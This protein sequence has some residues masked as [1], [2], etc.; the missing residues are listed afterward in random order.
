MARRTLRL[1]KREPVRDVKI[2]IQSDHAEAFAPQIEALLRLM[3][4]DPGQVLYTDLSRFYDFY[5][6]FGWPT[7]EHV[8]LE[9]DKLAARIHLDVK[10]DG[11]GTLVDAVRAIL[12]VL[13]HWPDSQEPSI[14]H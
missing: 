11:G 10:L 6:Q 4:Y 8:Q 5:D 7:T 13:P 12:Q 1:I 3:G 9:V 2:T 14:S